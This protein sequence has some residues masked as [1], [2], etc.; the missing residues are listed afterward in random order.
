MKPKNLAELKD[1]IRL[2]WKTLTPGV[3]RKFVG[4]L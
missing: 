3:C 4:H 1:G 2:Y